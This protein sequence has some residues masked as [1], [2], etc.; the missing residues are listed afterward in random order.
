MNGKVGL[1]CRNHLATVFP[2]LV[3]KWISSKSF[4]HFLPVYL[5]GSGL[6]D[7]DMSAASAAGV[8]QAYAWLPLRSYGLRFL[9]QA[10]WRVPSSR[11]AIIEAVFNQL[12]GLT[13]DRM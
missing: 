13:G 9:I 6:W 5:D 2:F 10:D 7:T 12:P 8:E 1:I 4:C 3:N 11:E